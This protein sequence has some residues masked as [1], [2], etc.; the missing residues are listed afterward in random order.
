MGI[1][2]RSHN[3]ELVEAVLVDG[4]A[5]EEVGKAEAG[6]LRWA[7]A[8]GA[9]VRRSFGILR[10]SGKPRA[11]QSGLSCHAAASLPCATKARRSSFTRSFNVEGMP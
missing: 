6:F 7:W 9:M 2:E 4:G 5:P 8:S 1:S 11:G 10:R 3:G